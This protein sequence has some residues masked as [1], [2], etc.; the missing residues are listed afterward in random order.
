MV[1]FFPSMMRWE[2]RDNYL[3]FSMVDAFPDMF[4]EDLLGLPLDREIEFCVDLVLRAQ[5]ISITQ[6]RMAPT[7]L[8]EL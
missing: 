3:G 7:K 5:P 1:V 2:Q 8:T 6:Y 4:L